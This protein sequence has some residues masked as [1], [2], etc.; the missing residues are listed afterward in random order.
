[1]PAK[2]SEPFKDFPISGSDSAIGWDC[3]SQA[4]TKAFD[5]YTADKSAKWAEAQR[6]IDDARC[7]AGCRK[8]IKGVSD[9][10][11]AERETY[12]ASARSSNLD[13]AS[14]YFGGVV[15][16]AIICVKGKPLPKKGRIDVRLSNR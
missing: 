10:L 13:Q 16:G 12:Q 1:M 2:C 9:H 8:E 4:K 3:Q 7:P 14:H 11:V 5:K 15:T 6:W